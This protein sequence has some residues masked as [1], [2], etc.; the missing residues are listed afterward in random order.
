MAWLPLLYRDFSPKGAAKSGDIFPFFTIFV[1]QIHDVSP[2][3]G[4]LKTHN[5]VGNPSA[6]R[7]SG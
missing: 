2:D 6:K 4:D 5:I 3:F 7:A 1:G